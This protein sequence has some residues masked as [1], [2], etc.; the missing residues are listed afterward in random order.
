VLP[1]GTVEIHGISNIGLVSKQKAK[2]RTNKINRIR[3]LEVII[4]DRSDSKNARMKAVQTRKLKIEELDKLDTIILGNN[5]DD[6]ID[7]NQNPPIHK[8]S[9]KFKDDTNI[10]KI[11]D[12]EG[13]IEPNSEEHVVY[14]EY[15]DGYGHK[16]MVKTS[17]FAP[18]AI[19]TN[20]F[21][22]THDG[23]VPKQKP[24]QSEN[25]PMSLIH[26]DHSRIQIPLIT[27]IPSPSPSD[28]SNRSS[29]SPIL[30]VTPLPNPKK[31]NQNPDDT[32]L[33]LPHF[34]YPR[35]NV[36]QRWDALKLDL[37]E[38]YRL[39]AI[40]EYALAF[41]TS[42]QTSKL[43][44]MCNLSNY[45]YRI[46]II[47]LFLDII[48]LLVSNLINLENVNKIINVGIF[49]MINMY[50]EQQD[51]VII[52]RKC[53]KIIASIGK[54]DVYKYVSIEVVSKKVFKKKDLV[55]TNSYCNILES[56][57]TDNNNIKNVSIL[58]IKSDVLYTL[59]NLSQHYYLK[60]M[61][62]LLVTMHNLIKSYD[63]NKNKSTLDLYRNI[64]KTIQDNA[65]NSTRNRKL[66]LLDKQNNT[67]QNND[68]IINKLAK[69][70]LLSIIR[71][72]S[73]DIVGYEINGVTHINDDKLNRIYKPQ[74]TLWNNN[75]NKNKNISPYDRSI[76]SVI[77]PAFQKLGRCP[78]N[79][80][81]NMHININD[82]RIFRST[83]STVKSK[84]YS[85]TNQPQESNSLRFLDNSKSASKT[86]TKLYNIKSQEI[87]IRNMTT[88]NNNNN[89]N[90][91]NNNNKIIIKNVKKNI[92]TEPTK[93]YKNM[94]P[95][96]VLY[97]QCVYNFCPM[98][99]RFR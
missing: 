78:N 36:F 41:I 8:N 5:D 9:R 32:L 10:N 1:P 15:I 76:N 77:C 17:Y 20:Q 6:E 50:I 2:Q 73:L 24:F 97:G 57:V 18:T 29:P 25:K 53:L 12:T 68:I 49:D 22:K 91:N 14:E 90:N 46:E 43:I 31:T 62:N 42:N 81:P 60:Q 88:N 58:L 95:N 96:E 47:S 86:Y 7:T 74:K 51:D 38:L 30:R 99:H 75:K 4:N 33:N 54:S 66:V 13:C 52:L 45:R 67:N 37:E 61:K 94:C 39:L 3:E 35:Y 72:M 89:I 93:P 21:T 44:H 82:S 59:A 19:P 63:T 85:N 70:H 28:H 34:S 48:S 80:C 26:T 92:K 27:H 79:N 64:D 55:L 83:N 11:D 71:S 87:R 40:P 98:V 69:L 56:F 84:R 23:Q 16:T 65:N